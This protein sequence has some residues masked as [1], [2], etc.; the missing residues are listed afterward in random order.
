MG[1]DART[2]YM[3]VL[4]DPFLVQQFLQ[5]FKSLHGYASLLRPSPIL[6]LALCSLSS[7]YM[8]AAVNKCRQVR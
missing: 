5:H 7:M 8:R 6:P 4:D 2:V 1:T 3:Y